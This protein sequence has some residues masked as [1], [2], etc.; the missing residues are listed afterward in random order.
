[1]GKAIRGFQF[2]SY[3]LDKLHTRLEGALSLWSQ[4]FQGQ[5]NCVFNKGDG[6]MYSPWDESEDKESEEGNE[7]IQACY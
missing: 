1:M 2:P 5:E 7:K 3:E 4:D 6:T